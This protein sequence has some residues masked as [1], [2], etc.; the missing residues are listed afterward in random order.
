MQTD[1]IQINKNGRFD[2]DLSLPVSYSSS[3]LYY[4]HAAKWRFRYC[5]M[6]ASILCRPLI[7]LGT[8]W[9]VAV[10]F[11]IALYT[12]FA[13]PIPG[14]VVD[15]DDH[16]SVERGSLIDLL[17]LGLA[18][19]PSCISY[20][21]TRS[22]AVVDS[23]KIR[24]KLLYKKLIGADR[25]DNI[26]HLIQRLRSKEQDVPNLLPLSLL[27][28]LFFVRTMNAISSGLGVI[29]IIAEF[30]QSNTDVPIFCAFDWDI[31][32]IGW[33]A[34]ALVGYFPFEE[35]MVALFVRHYFLMK[36]L[37]SMG[38]DRSLPP[39]TWFNKFRTF[40]M[41]F[42]MEV[43][44]F[45]SFSNTIEDFGLCNK[46]PG[47]RAHG[48]AMIVPLLLMPFGFIITAWGRVTGNRLKNAV[49]N[50]AAEI[51]IEQ[52]KRSHGEGDDSKD[53]TPHIK[54]MIDAYDLKINVAK[55]IAQTYEEELGPGVRKL[56]PNAY[57]YLARNTLLHS[58]SWYVSIDTFSA[59]FESALRDA[60]FEPADRIVLRVCLV[61][62][63]QKLHQS[64]N[65]VA[66]LR[67]SWIKRGV[68]G[69]MI[70]IPTLCVGLD[71]FQ[72]N[73]SIV[74]TSWYFFSSVI[75]LPG[76]L[77]P[78]VNDALSDPSVQ[79]AID[80]SCITFAILLVA[81]MFKASLTMGAIQAYDTIKNGALSCCSIF[82]RSPSRDM[83]RQSLLSP[84]NRGSAVPSSHLRMN[85][86]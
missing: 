45:Y 65:R 82:H 5:L 16:V 48:V 31:T 6:Y 42:T 79:L 36:N 60:A 59:A 44:Y 17:S 66:S 55:R 25:N 15:E 69:I 67:D 4:L 50:E 18:G 40:L 30:Q 76:L 24:D 84:S 12:H 19:I 81:N 57:D 28:A 13:V 38:L 56:S 68:F 26:W 53:I 64:K 46:V 49:E 29:K 20:F 74:T 83:E 35:F 63:K 14:V 80:V 72:T 11:S 54:N 7:A 51:R 47:K 23:L 27:V 78:Q 75:S 33:L 73:V 9:F 61:E 22:K 34:G 58:E 37:H 71:V 39:E 70:L 10:G 41:K 8:N 3:I 52:D 85:I 77:W 21:L 1:D 43:T 32:I 62:E 86:N 2:I